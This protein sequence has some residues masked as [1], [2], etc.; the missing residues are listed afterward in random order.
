MVMLWR[1]DEAVCDMSG[2]FSRKSSTLMLENL[3]KPAS[4]CLLTML[5]IPNCAPEDVGV[6]STEPGSGPN[7]DGLLIMS[8][9]I[10][11]VSAAARAELGSGDSWASLLWLGD[12]V[13]E[14]TVLM[15]FSWPLS[16][17]SNREFSALIAYS[18][19]TAILCCLSARLGP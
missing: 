6:S 2:G 5:A 19:A 1:T 17:E 13:E 8:L 12:W 15:G 7:S 4:P 9:E 18:K 11:C 10:A 3:E 16:L 14:A